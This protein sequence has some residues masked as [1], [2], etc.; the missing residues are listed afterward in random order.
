MR[1]EERN[2]IGY[3]Y[4]SMPPANKMIPEFLTEIVAVIEQEIV[5][6]TMSGIIVT[7]EGRHF[8]SGADVEKLTQWIRETTENPEENPV[9]SWFRKVKEAFTKLY[10]MKVPVVAAIRGFC[11]GS[12]FELA[13][14]CHY[15][16][17]EE[18]VNLGLPET[19]FGLLPGINGTFRMVE[20]LGYEKAFEL[21]MKGHLFGA[22]DAKELGL[23]QEV[24]PKK[25][26]LSR[27]EEWI[28]SQSKEKKKLVS[29][30]I[31]GKGKMGMDMFSYFMDYNCKVTLVCRKE[32]DANS[33]MDKI[34]KKLGRMKK[35]GT[36]T[37]QEYEEKLASICITSDYEKLASCQLV[38]ET[39]V[40][41]VEVKKQVIAKIEQCVGDDCV[42]ATNSSSIPL[43]E[44]F[45]E[46]RKKDRCLGIH[47]FFPIKYMGYVEIN[48][49]SEVSL[50]MVEQAAQWM[51]QLGKKSI[52]LEG[53]G[54]YILS[55][56]LT[57]ATAL[58]YA[59]YRKEQVPIAW[60]D[61][62]MKDK[63]M[64]FG[65]FEMIDSTGL[66]IILEC[67]RRFLDG[68]NKELLSTMLEEIKEAL[69]HGYVAGREYGFM[70]Y[71]QQK[72]S[73]ETQEDYEN[74]D[75]KER[76]LASVWTQMAEEI[77]WISDSGM[78]KDS[79]FVDAVN[80]VMGIQKE[81]LMQEKISK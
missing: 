24:V 1:Y 25:Q 68:R 2:Q 38:M 58:C 7:G 60:L 59:Q 27:A 36:L 54:R 56:M 63:L 29:I 76:I 62:L 6:T 9:P 49:W 15:R 79:G 55:R 5:H 22:K 33:I 73:W 11:I 18:N 48:G 3:L 13:L 70:A 71:E 37:E 40:E 42:I 51:K 61:E 77:K 45:S 28:R 53:E 66:Q 74:D 19:T 72:N 16:I 80:E 75:A 4:I 50:H 17:A 52:L 35:R 30:G 69:E 43:E 20:E 23:I 44:I 12:G 57:L 34:Q 78:V 26:A 41:L 65:P 46:C 8:S 67:N 47:F 39:V 21:I 14:H 10:G 31:V 81:F 32:E 64:L